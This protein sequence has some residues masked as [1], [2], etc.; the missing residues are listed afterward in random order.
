MTRVLGIASDAAPEGGPGQHL[1]REDPKRSQRLRSELAVGQQKLSAIF[2]NSPR[3]S[4]KAGELLGAANGWSGGI[5]HLRAGWACQFCSL[6]GG[7]QAILDIYLPGDVIGLDA[8]LRTR[9]LDEVMAVT[10]IMIERID[11]ENTLTDLMACPH[12]AL[13]IAWLFGQRQRR[14]DRLIAAISSLDAR[15]RVATMILDFHRRLSRQRL[16]TGAT[17]N[18][19]L[20]QIQIGAYLGLTVAHVNRVLRSLR[21][22][23][24]VN[25]EKH[26]VTILDLGHLTKLAQNGPLPSSI[27]GPEQRSLGEPTPVGGQHTLITTLPVSQ[28]GDPGL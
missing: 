15:G 8:V 21:N 20:T 25:V 22:E 17:Y 18:L 4:L 2:R 23:R 19:P 5:Y 26:C 13:Y 16:I 27:A 9:P 12:T 14:A 3:C 6:S 11:A 10:S 7:H 28:V 1:R 24:I